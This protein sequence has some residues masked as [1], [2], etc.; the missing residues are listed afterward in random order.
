MT[1]RSV[2]IDYREDRLEEIATYTRIHDVILCKI[3]RE[4]SKMRFKFTFE[5]E[6]ERQAR[7]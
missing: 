5:T 1:R 6:C 7:M 2:E 4:G 3:V